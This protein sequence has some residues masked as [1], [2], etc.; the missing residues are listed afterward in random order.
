MSSLSMSD[1]RPVCSNQTLSCSRVAVAFPPD[2]GLFSLPRCFL[3]L[4]LQEGMPKD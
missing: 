3:P 4:R 1:L 2:A